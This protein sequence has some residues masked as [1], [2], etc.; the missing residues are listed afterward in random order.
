MYKNSSITFDW[1]DSLK[2]TINATITIYLYISYSS[3]KRM[4]VILQNDRTFCDDD[5]PCYN[6]TLN[7]VILFIRISYRLY[8]MLK[9]KCHLLYYNATLHYIPINRITLCSCQRE[10]SLV[11]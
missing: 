2:I 11:K 8:K 4:M 1:L 5:V 10:E 7:F 3:D 9:C 6:E